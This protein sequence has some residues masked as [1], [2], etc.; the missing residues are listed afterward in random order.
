MFS[1]LD[2][3]EDGATLHALN[4]NGGVSLKLFYQFLHLRLV[5]TDCQPCHKHSTAFS[6]S[7]ICILFFLR[8]NSTVLFQG[9]RLLSPVSPGG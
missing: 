2:W 4:T 8:N 9:F 7:R 6:D 3:H 1:F 5:D